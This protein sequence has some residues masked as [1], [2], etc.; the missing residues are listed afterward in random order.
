M[1][2]VKSFALFLFLS[3]TLI[4]YCAR[5]YAQN[6]TQQLQISSSPN[7]V[8]SGARALG[9]GGA[10][11]A[12]ADDATAASWNPGGLIQIERP[13]VSMV[14]SYFARTDDFSSDSSSD[15]SGKSRTDSLDFNYISA[16]YPFALFNRNMVVSLNFQRLYDFNRD[17]DFTYSYQEQYDPV[18]NYGLTQDVTYDQSGG[19]SAISP[20]YCVEVTPQLSFG[21]TLNFW[22]DAFF[23]NGWKE[24]YKS[25]G[26]GHLTIGD[27]SYHYTTGTD[28][29]EK[30]SSLWGF[31]ANVGFLW[32]IT[33]FITIGGVFKSP[34]TASLHHKYESSFFQRYTDLAGAT[35]SDTKSYTEDIE[36]DFPMSYGLGI[37]FRFSDAFTCSLDI[38]RTEWGDFVYRDGSGAETSPIDGRPISE[39]DVGPTHQIR[40]GG[41]YL[42]IFEKML[43]P[44]RCGLFYDPEPGESGNR[45]FYGFSLGSGVSI[46]PVVFDAAYQFRFGTN[47][48]GEVLGNPGTTADVQQHKILISAIYHF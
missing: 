16:V 9:M 43:V 2:F 12:V 6:I 21:V 14:G 28:I 4:G 36:I 46:G 8:G 22:T 34:F 7:P 11:I 37:A 39:S 35:S 33:Q 38:Y 17:L 18:M 24:S 48:Q 29:H 10:F 1:G 25:R 42:L 45:D 15:P 19:L 27:T 30:Y 44:I 5:L 3:I 23:E 40:L 41:E 20:A 13:E 32:D 26:S 31:N 47:I